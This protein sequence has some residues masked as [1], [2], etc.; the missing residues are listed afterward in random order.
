MK[1]LPFKISSR[2]S[3]SS[4]SNVG[5]R[6]LFFFFFFQKKRDWRLVSGTLTFR[7]PLLVLDGSL[8]SFGNSKQK[9]SKY[10]ADMGQR[11]A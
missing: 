2:I 1:P 9:S 8:L 7:L 5:S 10:L 4:G 6:K 11:Q 3:C